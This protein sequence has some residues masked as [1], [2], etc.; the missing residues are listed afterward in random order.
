[1]WKKREEYGVFSGP[2]LQAYNLS[3][4]EMQ[5]WSDLLRITDSGDK[6][7]QGRWRNSIV[8][9]MICV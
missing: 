4:K 9:E 2:M 7:T 3:F 8:G 6:V 5:S 1:M